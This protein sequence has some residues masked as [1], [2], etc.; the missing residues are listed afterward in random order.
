MSQTFNLSHYSPVVQELLRVPRIPA[1]GPG[2]PN[3]NVSETLHALTLPLL[4]ENQPIKQR[5]MANCCIAALWL[6]HDYLDESHTISQSIETV[7][8]SYWHGIMHRREPDYFNAKYWF[9]RVRQHAIFPALGLTTAHMASSLKLPE[10]ARFL[11][12]GTW[13]PTAVVDLCESIAQRHKACETFVQQIAV[14]EWQMLFH[15]C[16]QC[17]IAES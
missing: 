1:L 14:V 16:W 12:S 10:N 13:Q 15:Y 17:A 7:T 6:W 3:T 9:N 5:E 2:K 4:F 11:T 8:G